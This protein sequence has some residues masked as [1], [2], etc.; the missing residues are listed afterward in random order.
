MTDTGGTMAATLTS[1]PLDTRAKLFRGFSDASRLSILE[2]LR[3]GPRNVGDIADET[4]LTQSNA[5]NHLAC[6]LDCGLVVRE[7][8]G[9]FVYYGLSDAR[10]AELLGMADEL[11]TEVAVGVASCRIYQVGA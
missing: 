1:V 4:G 5:S 6:L 11:L 8:R 2:A 3:A 9:R 7:R 10:V